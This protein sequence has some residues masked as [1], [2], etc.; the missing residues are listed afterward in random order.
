MSVVSN[1]LFLKFRGNS[2]FLNLPFETIREVPFKLGIP[3][4]S[5][6]NMASAR[7]GAALEIR[8]IRKKLR[9]IENLE[10]LERDLTDEELNKVRK[11]HKQRVILSI[12]TFYP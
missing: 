9:Q 5:G 8:K 10:N 2:N 3:F 1:T 7:T 4:T 12:V 6:W 11:Q